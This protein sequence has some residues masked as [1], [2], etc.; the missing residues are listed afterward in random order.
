[1][2]KTL[3]VLIA[4]FFLAALAFLNRD[5][6]MAQADEV[7]YQSPCNSPKLYSIGRIDQR[8]GISRE[9]FDQ[10]VSEAAGIWSA[11]YGRPVFAYDPES[12]FTVNMIYDAR[13]SLNEQIGDLKEEL[14]REDSVVKP[15]IAEYE[16]E[17]A[18][19][20]VRINRL[21]EEI[22]R[23]N[24]SGGAPPEEYDRIVRE[25]NQL[26]QEAEA[27]NAHA[28]SL[29]LRTEELNAKVGQLN[30]TVD[31]YNYALNFRPEGGK[32]ILDAKGERIEV[33]LY[34]TRQELVNLLAHEFGHALGIEHLDNP[35]AIMFSKTNGITV[36]SEDDLAALEVAC[37]RQN[38]VLTEYR[39][40]S[41]ALYQNVNELMLRVSD[42]R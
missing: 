38:V 8:F 42:T 14:D 3:I 4:A 16:R 26:Q 20:Q 40:F 36:P 33:N 27:L 22:S 10:A 35:E 32:Y 7:L 17:S 39:R 24:A 18:E 19:L 41:Y 9:H 5:A 11:A 25:Q 15:E 12:R 23:W 34:S 2:R 6:L 28:R 21:N 30:K 31:T 29:S 37:G 1:M 13:Q